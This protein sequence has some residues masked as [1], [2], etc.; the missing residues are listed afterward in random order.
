MCAFLV[1]AMKK[2]ETN[3]KNYMRKQQ[4]ET[5]CIKARVCRQFLVM[6]PRQLRAH[7]DPC[8][9]E[10]ERM[11]MLLIEYTLFSRLTII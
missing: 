9:Y 10:E 7:G 6:A 4:Q 2:L 11:R 8:E 5:S 3:Q 1:H